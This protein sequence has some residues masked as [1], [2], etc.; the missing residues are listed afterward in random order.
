M[1]MWGFSI[2][3]L[4]LWLFEKSLDANRNNRRRGGA[5]QSVREGW[6]KKEMEEE[7][8]QRGRGRRRKQQEHSGKEKGHQAEGSRGGELSCI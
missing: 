2:L 3:F 4:F 1:D 7:R 5:E 8:Q 6:R